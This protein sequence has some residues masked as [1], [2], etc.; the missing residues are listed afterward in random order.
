MIANVLFTGPLLPLRDLPWSVGETRVEVLREGTFFAHVASGPDGSIGRQVSFTAA[1]LHTMADVYSRAVAEGMFPGGG[2]KVDVNHAL[3]FGALDPASTAAR[4]RALRLEVGPHVDAETGFADGTLGLFAVTAWTKDGALEVAEGKFAGVSAELIHPD[5]ALSKSTGEK[6]G[7]WLFTGYTLCNDPFIPGLADVVAPKFNARQIVTLSTREP[8]AR[9]SETPTMKTLL[10]RLNLPADA[11][12]D[13]A[14][15]AVES[16]RSA[17]VELTEQRDT[18]RA[19]LVELEADR[20]DAL[21]TELLTEGHVTPAKLDAAMA[22]FANH[23]GTWSER[24]TF[25]FT[26]FAANTVQTMTPTPAPTDE[27]PPVVDR[28]S[29]VQARISNKF[30]ELCRDARESGI[31]LTPGRKFELLEDAERDVFAD[32]DARNDYLANTTEA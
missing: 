3:E 1:D 9:V 18:L 20:V 22:V 31:A 8:R 5:F 26:V 27:K 14:L 7:G 17:N 32:V 23:P 16:L 19:D 15:R 21:R 4:G 6:L 30:A 28:A 29:S 24:K 13:V 11:S 2:G 25:L 10:A 12:E